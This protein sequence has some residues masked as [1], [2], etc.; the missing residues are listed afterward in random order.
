MSSTSFQDLIKQFNQVRT[1]L[2]KE[3]E[4]KRSDFDYHLLKNKVRFEVAINQ[5]HKKFRTGIFSYLRHANPL[6]ILTAP[7]T[8][9]LIVPLL[10]LDLLAFIYQFI[11]FP[12]Y[13]IQK[14]N[15]SDYIAVDRHKLSYLNIFEK[16]NCV[17]CGYANGLLRYV[18]ELASMTEQ[19]WCPI[20]HARRIKNTHNRYWD[21]VD[22]GDADGY[23]EGFD[24]QRSK[25]KKS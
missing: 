7:V 21:F 23:V 19:F 25:V 22:Y 16:M 10:L 4:K 1:N 9:S 3:V 5:A 20:K 24:S 6:F 13:G 18:A 11:C 15:R 17:F 8:Y 14:P 12:V 2:E